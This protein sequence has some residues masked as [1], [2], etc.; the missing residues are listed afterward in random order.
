MIA[1]AS[2]I[3][4]ATK[5]LGFYAEEEALRAISEISLPLESI[6]HS[7]REMAHS[8]RNSTKDMVR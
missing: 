7:T 6:A 5:T 1:Q 4:L 2:H 8:T 3:C